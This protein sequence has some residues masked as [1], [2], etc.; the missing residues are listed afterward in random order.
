MKNNTSKVT[1]GISDADGV[2]KNPLTEDFNYKISLMGYQTTEGFIH[3]KNKRDTT[4]YVKPINY[5][6]NQVVVTGSKAPRP[7]KLSPVITQ[8]I[9]SDQL[10]E[11]G[12]VG[13][14]NA[15]MQEIPG[16]NFQKVGFGT[17][18]NVSGLDARHVLF[19]IDGERLTGEMAGNID[20]QRF[21]LH[22]I[23]RIEIVKG[24]S[25]TLY[26]SRAAGAVIN[27][28]TKKTNK[29]FEAKGGVRY[30]QMNQVNYEDPSKSD[31]LYMYEKNVDKPNMQTWLSLGSKIGK[32]T[33]QTDMWYS[34]SDA[35]YL[36]QSQ[37]DKKY[38][39]AN[40]SIG[41]LKDTIITSW[42][43]RPPLGIE[44]SE[45]LN[46]SQKL[47]F[48][49][50]KNISLQL[51]GSGFL[52]NTYDMVQDLQF[53]QA[54]DLTMGFKSNIQLGKA[55]NTT[56]SLHT[57]KYKR[58]KRQERVDTREVVYDSQIYQPRLF[59]TSDI[60]K[61]NLIMGGI[62][63]YEDVLTSD[64][65]KNNQLSTQKKQD[66]EYFLQDELNIGQRFTLT[67][68][69]RASYNENY[70]TNIAPK[71]AL[72]FNPTDQFT[73]RFN[74][75]SGYRSP[76]IKELYF[77][78]DHLGMFQ[79]IGDEFLNP[80]KNNYFSLSG[81]FENRDL[82][83]SANL[84]ANNFKNKIEGVWR[85]YDFQYNFEYRN[86]SQSNIKGAEIMGRI[87][88]F[89]PCIL[90]VSYS[91]VDVEKIDGVQ[92]NTSSPHTG[93]IRLSYKYDKRNY[94]LTS[95][96]SVA[97]TGQK[98]FSIQDRIVHNNKTYDAFF[99]VEIPTY[100]LCNFSITQKFRKCL[101]LT[102][103]VDN[104]L[105]YTPETLGSGVTMFN[106]PAT[107]GRRGFVQLE[108]QMDKI[109]HLLSNK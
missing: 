109:D 52:L 48:E 77:N 84:Y 63:Y 23:D 94:S 42:L 16:L 25:S 40:P 62:E 37:K 56:I 57:D 101:N 9:A 18:I 47:Y 34:T 87:K 28:I 105:N 29:K 82:F 53:D 92:L 7:I 72:K 43:P 20:Y 108:L 3:Y 46:V 55:L 102:V 32:F 83:L 104:F 58:Y 49:P 88:L 80:E 60:I 22:A 93:S 21:N 6:L 33:L 26:G 44:G 15:L 85:V 51:Y 68:G 45:H 31:F 69:F 30:G 24:A 38:F 65:F 41:L 50:T 81:Q 14:Q 95:N 76:S 11:S 91:Y 39:P 89:D 78:W 5:G 86:L 107:A 12:Y 64:R 54:E 66:L 36:F 59:F 74:Y 100:C 71:L 8:V 70:G 96:M 106:V 27:L 99:D 79:I 35:Y 103:G 2:I 1:G 19:L 73:F 4:I 17:D 67:G 75:A 98:D 97:I 90:N 13:I 10:A 61:N